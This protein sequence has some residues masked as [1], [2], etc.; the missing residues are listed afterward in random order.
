MV[1]V[2]GG[3]WGVGDIAGRRAR[4]QQAC[5]RSAAIVC[6]AGRNEQLGEQAARGLRRRA[7]GARVRLHRPHARAAGGGRRARALDRRRHLPGGEGGR[8]AGRLLRAARRPR[9]PEH[10]RDGRARP[11]AP[12]QRHRRAA[13]ARAGELRRRD[14]AARGEHAEELLGATVE[15]AAAAD[16]AV[17]TRRMPCSDAARG[18]CSP[19][20]PR[21]AVLDA[22]PRA[23]IPCGGCGW[24]RSLAAA[25]AGRRLVDDVHRRGDRACAK[26]SSRARTRPRQHRA[27]GR[28]AD[29]A[30]AGRRLPL[31]ARELAGRAS[32]SRSPTTRRA[33]ARDDR[34]SCARSATSC[35]RKCPA[36]RRCAGCARAARCARRRARSACSH[37]LLLPA[38]ARRAVGR[39][40]GARAHRRRDPRK[41]ALRI[42]ATGRAA[43]AADAG[44]R[45]AGRRRRRLA[46]SVAGLER[47]VSWL[48]SE[49]L[50]A[51]PLAG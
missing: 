3:G 36:R 41:G 46:A 23:P 20:P 24:S 30:R 16:R 32:T 17:A 48:G 35:C 18:A 12:G 25:A 49:G 1:V 39:S 22:P 38:P 8:H 34:R 2:S 10:A 11:A 27:A 7:A 6:L 13:R 44:R 40:A 19:I 43:S 45:R 15:P 5:R 47:I 29:R 33:H 50:G 14:G 28:R 31:V 42:S 4:V 21:G 26:V 37:Q 9:A 51:E